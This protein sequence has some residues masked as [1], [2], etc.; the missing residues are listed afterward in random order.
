[1]TDEELLAA[2]Q[3]DRLRGRNLRRA[4]RGRVPSALR[5]LLE[6]GEV[7]PDER[8]VLFNTGSGL[9]VP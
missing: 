5:R 3:G 6:R 1:M 8:V 4:R 9:K 7:K 2:G